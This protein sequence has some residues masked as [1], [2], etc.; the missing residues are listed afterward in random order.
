MR[1][2]KQALRSSLSQAEEPHLVYRM[3]VVRYSKNQG[4]EEDFAR[5]RK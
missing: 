4:V 2:R 3:T 1:H 5:F